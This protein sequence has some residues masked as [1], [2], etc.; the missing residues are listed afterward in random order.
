MGTDN[1]WDNGF[2]PYTR[3]YNVANVGNNW[4]GKCEF[5]FRNCAVLFCSSGNAGFFQF[6]MRKSQMEQNF[7]F[8]G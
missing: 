6:N 3:A 2:M 4:V 7:Y 5:L 1:W 8:L